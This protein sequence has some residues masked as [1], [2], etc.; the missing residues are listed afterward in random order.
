[1]EPFL[2]VNFGGPRHT[3][4]IEAF[5]TELLFD[6]DLIRTRFPDFLHRFLFR[7][8]ARKRTLNLRHDYEQIGGKSPIMMTPN[9]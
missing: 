2:L 8:V 4:E 3:D 1:M 9:F 7:R 5:L 6:R